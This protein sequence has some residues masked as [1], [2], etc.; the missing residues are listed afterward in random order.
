MII[1]ICGSYGDFSIYNIYI[2]VGKLLIVF[3]VVIIIMEIL[4]LCVFGIILICY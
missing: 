1:I 2:L 4:S 3:M